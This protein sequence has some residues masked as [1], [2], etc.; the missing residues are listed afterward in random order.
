MGEGDAFRGRV[1]AQVLTGG[2]I[3]VVVLIV[4]EGHTPVRALG[5]P[6]HR[7]MEANV[8]RFAFG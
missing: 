3:A 2:R 5:V 7:G 8:D 1:G 6:V 4:A